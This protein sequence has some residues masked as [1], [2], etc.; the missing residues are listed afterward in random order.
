MK[1]PVVS[2]DRLPQGKYM[3]T[4]QQIPSEKKL[5]VAPPAAQS[6]LKMH[7]IIVYARYWKATV[8]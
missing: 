6:R 5:R 2:V 8:N 7:G 4:N 1:D 3:M